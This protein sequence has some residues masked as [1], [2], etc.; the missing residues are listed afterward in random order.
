M[1][2]AL[3][4]TAAILNVFNFMYSAKTTALATAQFAAPP[5]PPTF[6]DSAAIWD[7]Q[8]YKLMPLPEDT[9]RKRGLPEPSTHRLQKRHFGSKADVK[10]MRSSGLV[11]RR[12]SAVIKVTGELGGDADDAKLSKRWITSA[13]VGAG[14]GAVFAP[15]FVSTLNGKKPDVEEPPFNPYDSKMLKPKDPFIA[16]AADP[17]QPLP[18]LPLSQD[19][20]STAPATSPNVDNTRYPA[21]SYGTPSTVYTHG[22]STTN[23]AAGQNQ[24]AYPGAGYAGMTSEASGA[25]EAAPVLRKRTVVPN[26]PSGGGH[27]DATSSS[28]LHK[29]LLFHGG[30]A[31]KVA[32][33]ITAG[34][35]VPLIYEGVMHSRWRTANPRDREILSQ[36]DDTPTYGAVGVPGHVPGQLATNAMPGYMDYVKQLEQE[37]AQ[38]QAPSLASTNSA[39]QDKQVTQPGTSADASSDTTDTSPGGDPVLRRRALAWNGEHGLEKRGGW[40]LG[41][42]LAGIGAILG[43]AQ[44]AT[45]FPQDRDE[46]KD[47][48]RR[49]AKKKQQEMLAAQQAQMG[50]APQGAGEYPTGS[51]YAGSAGS[52]SP[53]AGASAAGQTSTSSYGYDGASRVAPS[54]GL[55]G[56]SPSF[57][58]TGGSYGGSGGGGGGSPS[59]SGAGG[60]Y[61]GSGGGG[62]AS[63]LGD[64]LNAAAGLQASSGGSGGSVLK[65]RDS[66]SWDDQFHRQTLSKRNPGFGNALTIGGTTMFVGTLAANL[67]VGS[68]Q[69]DKPVP[70][71]TPNANTRGP[72]II[73]G[74]LYAEYLASKRPAAAGGAAG[75]GLMGGTGYAGAPAT[76]MSA[77]SGSGGPSSQSSAQTGGASGAD[78]DTSSDDAASDTSG[79]NDPVLKK[80]HE[81]LQKRSPT[82][83]EFAVL[84]AEAPAMAELAVGTL[85]R[86]RG[87]SAA[88]EAASSSSSLLR[89]A[90][91]A[92]ASDGT[93]VSSAAARS[94]ALSRY[95][96]SRVGSGVA[97]EGALAPEGSLSALARSNSLSGMGRGS[98]MEGLS[99]SAYRPAAAWGSASPAMAADLRAGTGLAGTP[100]TIEGAAARDATG[101]KPT[102]VVKAM[103]QIG[104]G[105]G[106]TMTMNGFN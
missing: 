63:G 3:G 32:G 70:L 61:G 38:R 76:A 93:G 51:G 44:S 33:A 34:S 67:W 98:A 60:S 1:A 99:Y 75:G 4:L 90:A 31:A 53:Y 79:S 81:R 94:A 97:R 50:G 28:G 35:V 65:K 89:P 57:S 83:P 101:K 13:L 46:E 6:I 88:T 9:K 21:V 87:A 58:G 41:I 37:Q 26:S 25:S 23:P 5:N 73:G 54:Y 85:A 104:N 43:Y 19:M 74:D 95:L 78:A 71:V 62:G 30:P 96:P 64:S 82:V 72:Q 84:E 18:V 80:R 17:N 16:A 39:M 66:A 15:N 11:E 47:K 40:G 105:A 27:S 14:L 77:A 103:G 7:G 52:Y 86:L 68:K 91:G 49:E 22:Q 24:A 29:R 100:A 10:P 69:K 45:Q 92:L 59:F 36:L 20:P 56:G 55:G 12:A 8:Q 2:S 48:K 42:G 106:S 102:G